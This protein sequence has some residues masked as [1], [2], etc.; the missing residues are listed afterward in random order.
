MAEST[1]ALAEYVLHR[2]DPTDDP[3]RAQVLADA[4]SEAGDL[5]LVAAALDRAFG[6]APHLAD[7]AAGRAAAL[8]ALAIK[9][10]GLIFRYVPT[11]TFS[12]GSPHGDL[13][14]QPV[15]PVLAGGFWLSDTPVSW[16][17]YCRLMGWEP[18]AASG[19][20]ANAQSFAL[21]QET[22]I[23]LQYCEAA[24]A[25]DF[26]RKPMV[27]VSWQSAEE[28]AERLSTAGV[29][30]GLPTEAEWEKAARGGLLARRYSWGDEPPDNE[31]CD[32]G[33]FGE[34]VIRPPRELP[35]NGYGLHGMCGGVSEWTSD[36]Y[37]ALAYHPRRPPA[38]PGAPQLR[39]LRGGSFTDDAAAVT[40]S[41]RMAL[42]SSN[43]RTALPRTGR[44]ES[45]NI[46]FRL[47][48]RE[49]AL[50]E[51][52]PRSWLRKLFGKG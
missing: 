33:H 45:P 52:K 44:H 2:A 19:R 25:G 30:Y 32:F 40:V 9:E 13:D 46:G 51:P 24:E 21:S 10:H 42:T 36:V 16:D 18:P 5:K 22:K 1:Q 48:R 12:M 31:R 26:D 41:F 11:G 4:A 34:F 23:R 47:V 27:A 39:V 37:D 15:H 43:W 20:P 17:A 28:L 29:Q 49:G 14:E 7:I 6:L 50:P 8:D 38:A 3:T 35:P